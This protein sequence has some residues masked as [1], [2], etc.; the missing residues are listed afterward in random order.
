[1]SSRS[2]ATSISE[3][4]LA[5]SRAV[6]P[7]SERRTTPS[8]RSSGAWAFRIA[9][10]SSRLIRKSYHKTASERMTLRQQHNRYRGLAGLEIAVRL[11]GILQGIGVVV[12]DLDDALAHHIEQLPGVGEQVGALGD[13]GV[14]RRSRGV[15]RDLGRQSENVEIG[16]GAGGIAEADP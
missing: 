2:T 3:L 4:V 15:E 16:D 5:S 7:N 9:R 10:A 11:H 8:S 14:Q 6:E 1:M 13:V 12:L